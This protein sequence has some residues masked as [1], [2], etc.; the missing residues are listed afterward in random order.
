[1]KWTLSRLVEYAPG[2][3]RTMHPIYSVLLRQ[4]VAWRLILDGYQ[5]DFIFISGKGA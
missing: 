4:R 3:H 5:P 2:Y 1:M